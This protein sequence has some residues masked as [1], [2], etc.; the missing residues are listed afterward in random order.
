MVLDYTQKFESFGGRTM[1]DKLD[2]RDRRAIR[3]AAF[4]YRL[5]FQEFRQV[6]EYGRDLAM[7][8]EAPLSQWLETRGDTGANDKKSKL[9]TDLQAHVRTLKKRP[10]AYSASQPLRPVTRVS[11]PVVSRKSGKA[12]FGMC[13]VASPK[14]VCCNLR[15]ID[16]VE[17]CVFGCSY[18]AVQTF[19]NDEITF[20]DDLA[21]KLEAI[22]LDPDRPYHIGTGQSSDSLAW[23]NRNGALGSLL[24]FAARHPNV[25]LEFKTKSDNVRYLI[26]NEV[27]PNIVCSWSMNTPTIIDN[28]EHFTANLERRLF[29]ARQVADRGI[30]VAFHFHPMVYYEGWREDYIALAGRI[31]GAFTPSEVAFMSLGSV[32]LTKPVIRKIR[33]AGNPTRILQMEMVADPHGKLTYPDAVKIEMFNTMLSALAP[34]CQNVFTYLCMEKSEIWERTLERTYQDNEAFELDFAR[35]TGIVDRLEEGSRR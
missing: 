29:A 32:T 1:Y 27:P 22:S 31:V 4:A 25:L 11:R 30:K 33:E 18:C 15:T 26:E 19:Y 23:G 12:I 17:N 5:T 14:T 16:A 10:K 20:D 21:A 7:W 13:P 35:H 24:A 6:V 28:E 34:W 8:G 2:A 9:L 3:E